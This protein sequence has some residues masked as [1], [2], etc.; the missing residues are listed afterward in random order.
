MVVRDTTGNI[1]GGSA[2]KRDTMAKSF[3]FNF[4][5]MDE[6]SPPS[7]YTR[8]GI[9]LGDLFI[10]PNVS[11]WATNDFPGWKIDTASRGNLSFIGSYLYS[12]N[13]DKIEIFEF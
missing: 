3:V 5:N 9:Q 6:Y 12:T 8:D 13:I 7:H 4:T 1:Y 11:L 2:P 10:K